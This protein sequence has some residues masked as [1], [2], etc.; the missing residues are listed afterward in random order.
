MYDWDVIPVVSAAVE[1]SEYNPV[2]LVLRLKFHDGWK[3]YDYCGV[4]QWLANE[5]LTPHPWGRIGHLMKNYT[6]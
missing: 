3:I 2:T 6:C 5:F 4:P 1:A